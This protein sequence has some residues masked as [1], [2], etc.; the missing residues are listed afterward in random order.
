VATITRPV[1]ELQAFKR[2]TLDP[3]E[4]CRITFHLPV[5][6]LGFC[7]PDLSYVLEPGE[8]E[9]LVGSSSADAE[10]LRRVTIAGS[11]MI[12]ATRPS[13]GGITVCPT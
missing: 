11:S 6:A 3:G 5:D 1:L 10:V 9:L 7:G 2:V 12:P 13:M 8:V 4:R